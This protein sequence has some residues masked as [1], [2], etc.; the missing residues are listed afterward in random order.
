MDQLV[1]HPH[2]KEQVSQ[3]I[4]TPTHAMLLTGSDGVGKFT[5]AEHI[6]LEVLGVAPDKAYT[7]LKIVSPDEKNTIS[8]ESVRELQRYLQ[9]KTL[10]RQAFRRAVIVEHAQR[11][12]TEAQ[13]AFLKILEEP[14][15]DT[16]LLLT[17][18][19]PRSL[20]PTIMSR[21]Q[22]I[23]VSAPS[24]E[25]VRAFFGAA[26]KDATAIS[27]AYFLAGGLPGLMSA[28]LVGDDT[29]PL[30][31][32]VADAKAI[33]QKQTFER[34]AMVE[35]LS[36]QKETAKYVLQALQHIAQ[37]GLDQAA[38]KEDLAKIKQWHHIL[39]VST[40]ALNAMAQNANTK[41]VLSNAMLK[42]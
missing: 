28:L 18:D 34:L 22:A 40:N 1:L 3:F 37:T 9:L 13:N 26:G 21:L 24:E 4:A 15:Q 8:I 42:L 20:L 16:I 33:L 6:A 25:A 38:K 10:G 41:L 12:T 31:A 7:A 29:H 27:Q 11:M 39:K 5:L 14:P 23:S 19:N 32:G 35:G 17:V 2:T 36:K 30:L